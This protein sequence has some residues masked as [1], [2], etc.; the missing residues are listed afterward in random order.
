[1]TYGDSSKKM[2]FP[3]QEVDVAKAREVDRMRVEMQSH[4]LDAKAARGRDGVT[5]RE[6]PPGLVCSA[7]L[8]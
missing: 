6:V 2:A 4:I 7:R 5:E 8:P 3:R 1:M